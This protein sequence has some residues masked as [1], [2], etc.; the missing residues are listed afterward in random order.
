MLTGYKHTVYEQQ[1]QH[2]FSA[3]TLKDYGTVVVFC[4]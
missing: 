4:Y 1:Q 2:A 3:S